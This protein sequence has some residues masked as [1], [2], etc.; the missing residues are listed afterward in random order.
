MSST[1]LN[2]GSNDRSAVLSYIL[3]ARLTAELGMLTDSSFNNFI[4]SWNP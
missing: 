3:V 2:Y 1:T 4:M